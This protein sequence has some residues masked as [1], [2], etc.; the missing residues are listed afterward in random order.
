MNSV[1]LSKSDLILGVFLIAL[2]VYV[3]LTSSRFPAFV[4]R[5]QK[6]PGPSFFPALLSYLL[7]GFGVVLLVQSSTIRRK[8]LISKVEIDS[9]GIVNF[10][11]V[12]VSV[13]AFLPLCELFGL[14]LTTLILGT[15]MMVLIGI[16]WYAS[17]LYSLTLGLLVKF[18]FIDL[19][20]VAL[21]SGYLLKVFGR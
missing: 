12:V 16:K 3:L 20:K 15:G 13:F 1:K 19:F 5:G 11:A 14:L 21:P 2:A 6:L 9:G 4:L 8:E 17:I 10:F 7:I 18:V